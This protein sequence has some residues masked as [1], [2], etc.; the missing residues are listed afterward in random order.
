MNDPLAP[1]QSILYMK[2]GTHANEDLDS[3]IA[4]KQEEIDREGYSLWG[5]GGNT[6]HPAT[7]VQPF[8]RQVA[9]RGDQ[10]VLA[11]QPMNSKHFAEPVRATQMSR[12][13]IDWEAIP[14]AINALGS[15]YALAIGSLE[16]ADIDL[17]LSRTRVAVGNSIG[18]VGSKYIRGRV[19]KACLD[20]IDG[21][22][23]GP[24]V[25][26][27]LAAAIVDPYAVFLRN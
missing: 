1:G 26:I 10:L 18:R 23:G 27:G 2:V 5:Y 24:E 21:E 3:I 22:E 6:C 16:H 12:N 8:A 11:M 17:P 9:E 15:R 25:H 19:D 20:I 7:M 14:D 13:G 4:R